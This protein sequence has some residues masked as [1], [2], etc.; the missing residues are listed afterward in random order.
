MTKLTPDLLERAHALAGQAIGARTE[1]TL[2]NMCGAIRALADP[3]REGVTP[4]AT[5]LTPRLVACLL[6]T[7]GFEKISVTGEGSTRDALYRKTDRR[8]PQS[9]ER[10]RGL[11][12][13]RDWRERNK[14]YFDAIYGAAPACACGVAA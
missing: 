7:R 5:A 9:A 8:N 12:F 4:L 6:R 10:A 3:A 14:P 13:A 11:A 2:V 1:V